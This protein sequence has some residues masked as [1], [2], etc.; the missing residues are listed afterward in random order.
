M[1][2]YFFDNWESIARTLTITISAYLILIFFLRVSGKRTL[3][4]M[5]AFDFI[6][7]I[8][9][10]SCLATVALNKEVALADGALVF[11]Y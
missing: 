4:K 9:L 8:A 7:T 2:N 10:G 11:F 3:S 5:N 1:E 6:I